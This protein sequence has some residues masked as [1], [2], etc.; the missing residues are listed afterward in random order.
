MALIN[1]NH[2]LTFLFLTLLLFGGVTLISWG[3]TAASPQ[4]SYLTAV[5]ITDHALTGEDTS[6]SRTLRV[7][8]GPNNAHVFWREQNTANTGFDLFY[9][10]LPGGTTQRLSNVVAANNADVFLY[11]TIQISA[12]NIPHVIWEEYT[13]SFDS[14]D[15]N[16][17]NP[18]DG[19]VSLVS[20]TP[21][22]GYNNFRP[23]LWLDGDDAHV[24]WQQLNAT[25]TESV[26]MYWNSVSQTA[27]EL[28]GFEAG[29]VHN[30][31]LHITWEG[32]F[33]GPVN[34]WN[35]KTQSVFT[36]PNSATSGDAS[37]HQRGIFADTNGQITIFYGHSGYS[38][39]ATTCL[40]SWNSSSQATS[41]HIAGTK[42]FSVAPVQKDNQGVYHSYAVDSDSGFLPYYWNSNL[43]NAI[44]FDVSSAGTGFTI[45][46]GD[47]YLAENGKAHIV[48][49][50]D[51]DLFYWNPVDQQVINLSEAS[52]PN[53][54]IASY[55]RFT[56]FDSSGN[57]TIIWQEQANSASPTGP[58]YWQ[59]EEKITTNIL[60]KLGMS[61]IN[62]QS[63]RKKMPLG[64]FIYFT[65]CQRL[66]SQALSI[67]T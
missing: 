47:L 52:G 20:Q 14:R 17:W 57:L 29:L 64:Q 18:V 61:S 7:A 25:Q 22:I 60:M 43:T 31:V 6:Y 15:V 11:P 8:M 41:I 26:Y 37:V 19:V 5:Q 9:R 34:Y 65:E 10:S 35:S 13:S 40:A 1:T 50:D 49:E 63:F 36:L 28:P 21:T 62:E 3:E 42:C 51:D 4:G 39:P 32:S 46:G 33:N 56:S 67:G 16:Y 30:G 27:L 44:F 53:S 66:G 48:W 2:K 24:V 45:P 38:D 58:F 12:V 54:H 59:S 55:F 23:I